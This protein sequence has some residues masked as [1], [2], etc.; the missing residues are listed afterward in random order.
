MR[1]NRLSSLRSKSSREAL[2]TYHKKILDTLDAVM[3]KELKNIEKAADM[4]TD[5]FINNNLL[6]VF[7]S[8]HSMIIAWEMFQRAGG[9]VPV[10]AWLDPCLSYFEARKSLRTERISGYGKMLVDYY[11]PTKDDILLVVSLSGINAVP[12][13]VAM[14]TKKRGT[15]VLGLTSVEASSRLQPRNKYGKRLYEIADLTIDNHVPYGDAV[16]EM[17]DSP[18]PVGPLSTVVNATIVNL[19]GIRVAENFI[20]RG[21]EPPVWASSNVPGGEEMNK[22]FVEKYKH[23]KIHH[24]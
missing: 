12:V 8:G 19:M 5:C 23:G 1:E 11:D 2:I 16:I 20:E 18:K 3:T 21:L 13:E 15:Y 7:G 10:N 22:S 9:L 24:M 6:H 4:I 14:E 17:K